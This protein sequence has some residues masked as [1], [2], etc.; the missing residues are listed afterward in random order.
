MSDEVVV[1]KTFNNEIEAGMAQ[2]VLQEAGMSAFVFKDDAG[3]MEPQLQRTNG[4]R[5]VVSRIDSRRAQKLLK[6]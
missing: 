6:T 2:Q 3:G 1:L 4:V 5:L